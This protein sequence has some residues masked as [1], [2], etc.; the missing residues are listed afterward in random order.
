MEVPLS[1]QFPTNQMEFEKLLATEKQCEQLLMALKWPTG[2]ACP[3]CQWPKAWKKSRERF[4]CV[5]CRSETTLTR[6]TLFKGT[7]TPL[8]QWFQAIW[9]ITGQKYGVSAL[10]FQRIMGLPVYETAWI[11][12]HKLRVAMASTGQDKLAG[13]VQVDEAY[14]GGVQSG[15]KALGGRYGKVLVGVAVEVIEYQHKGKTLLAVGRIR[16]SVIKDRSADVLQA[17]VQQFVEPGTSVITD[18]WSGYSGLPKL[19]YLHHGEADSKNPLPKAHLVI[20]LLKRWM[21]GTH[22]GRISAKYL[23]R[24]LNEF[25]FRF[26]RRRAGDRG[27][28]FKTLLQLCVDHP[29]TTCTQLA[30]LET[31]K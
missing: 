5:N 12:L 7:K 20:S 8:R 10:G 23:Q 26:N 4:V 22:Q 25:V 30:A 13:I 16:L 17:F 15:P 18:G 2:F 3:R 6:N 1:T 21:M 9:W 19:G 28:L 27:V 14:V 31:H 24:Y 29:G 11:W